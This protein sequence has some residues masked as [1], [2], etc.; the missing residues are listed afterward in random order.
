MSLTDIT[1]IL[2][3]TCIHTLLAVA[4]AYL[5]ASLH[6]YRRFLFVGYVV[7]FGLVAMAGLLALVGFGELA[8]GLRSFGWWLVLPVTAGV[9]LALA[10]DKWLFQQGLTIRQP[11]NH[12]NRLGAIHHGGVT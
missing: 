1:F 10:L 7:A 6:G 9:I 4:A 11:N 8:M 5:V 3:N 12:K 2:I